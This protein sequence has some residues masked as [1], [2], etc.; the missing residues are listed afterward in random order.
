MQTFGHLLRI[1]RRRCADPL[2][3]GLLTQERL[4]ELI[5]AEIGDVGYSGAAVSDWERDKSK[6]N[7]D[8]RLVRVPAPTTSRDSP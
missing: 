8:D 1:Y 7:A 6:I 2:R 4:G 5:G 3:G